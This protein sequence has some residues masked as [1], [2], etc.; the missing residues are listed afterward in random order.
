MSR[1]PAFARAS[2]IV[3]LGLVALNAASPASAGLTLTGAGTTAGFT[4]SNF[5]TG[6]TP[7]GS[8]GPLGIAVTPGG[9]MVSDY[10]GAVRLFTDVDGQ[11]VANA[12]GTT[13]FGTSNAIGMASIGGVAYLSNQGQGDVF[14]LNAD[15]SVNSLVVHT[16]HSLN[17]LISNP[18][19]G[20]LLVSDNTSGAI[21]DID[22][23]NGT[24]TTVISGVSA[25]DG[26]SL[27]ADNSTV[28]VASQNN[29]LGY[30][31]SSHAQV[32]THA[33]NLVDGT[34]VGTG[35]LSGYIFGNT[36]DGN[37]YQVDLFSGAETLIASGGSR[38]DFVGVDTNN[39]SL[40]ISQTD[41]MV[42]LTA[43]A[44]S[45]FGADTP[46]PGTLALFAGA[47][48]AALAVR[49]RAKKQ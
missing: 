17:G 41:R 4:L 23:S 1:F 43:P 10:P 27:S 36:N 37:V 8:V 31:L 38:G 16:G 32:F 46:E 45:S 44:G 33:L 11:T 22:P 30:D 29:I 12:L 39:G 42:R 7:N 6:F 2:L 14:R 48:I 34:A 3:V 28:Y 21:L 25:P 19:T 47:S 5:V 49:R 9:I 13:N 35:A 18:V 40:L 26:L 15:T 20:H 24:V